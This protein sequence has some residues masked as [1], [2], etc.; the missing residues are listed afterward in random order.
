MFSHF[1]YNYY[2]KK[3]HPIYASGWIIPCLRTSDFQF[4]N[5]SQSNFS[6][7][8]FPIVLWK[9]SNSILSEFTK[10]KEG[11]SSNSLPNLK[12][13]KSLII[14]SM[15]IYIYISMSVFCSCLCVFTLLLDW[16]RVCEYAEQALL[17]TGPV[18]S[19][20]VLGL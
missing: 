13:T 5:M 3:N 10:C 12:N 11:R 2:S 7:G 16:S 1:K 20:P 19:Q 6:M 9:K 8:V 18:D 4:L 17:E 15:C 14:F